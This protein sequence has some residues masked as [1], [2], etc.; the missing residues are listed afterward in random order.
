[1]EE[2]EEASMVVV[3]MVVVV[4]VLA[5]L[6][7]VLSWGPLSSSFSGSN[8]VSTMQAGFPRKLYSQET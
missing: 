6:V 4:V 2:E 7:V 5:V 1:M 3:R 8:G